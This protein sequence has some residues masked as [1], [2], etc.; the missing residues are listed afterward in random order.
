MFYNGILL[1]NQAWSSG[2][3]QFDG[4]YSAYPLRFDGKVRNKTLINELGELPQFSQLPDS[5]SSIS[6]FDYARGDYG[7][8]ILDL[9]V[10]YSA[11]NNFLKLS[12][13]KRSTMG[14]SAHYI[15]PLIQNNPIHQSYRIDYSN[16]N[17][18]E[19][20]ELSVGRYITKS[21]IPDLLQNGYENDNIF[22]SALRY[23]KK[24]NN[25]TINS[26]ASQFSQNRIL[27]HSAYSDSSSQFINSTVF[28]LQIENKKGYHFGIN[29]KFHQLNK[30]SNFRP[31]KRS[32]VYIKKDFD[33]LFL[34][35]GTQISDKELYQP[36][37]FSFV[38]K[39]SFNLGRI[40]FESFGQSRPTH[41]QKA[42]ENEFESRLR[43][44]L[45]HDLKFNNLFIQSY[46]TNLALSADSLYSNTFS[47]AGINTSYAF[48][49]EWRVYSNI[50]SLVNSSIE[51]Q[52]GMKIES[53][54]MGALKIF[55]GNM[56][57]NF[58]VWSDYYQN[59]NSDFS[60]DPYMQ[61]QHEN[62]TE[63]YEIINRSVT[64]IELEANV[65]GVLLNLKIFN[66]LNFID[67]SKSTF[68]PNAAYP[69]IGRMVQ[70][71][72][73]WYFEN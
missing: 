40:K 31:L 53:G 41:P 1:S 69:E 22:N 6:Y 19:R 30:A 48:S 70:F 14:N 50:F 4:S 16:Y 7:L 2:I 66:L 36:F 56:I 73:R 37:I 68:K 15:H 13:F 25:W 57:I 28:D 55:S 52:F 59:N 3:L 20:I 26:Y 18:D 33:N 32:S 61:Y 63:N 11:K 58:H 27:I 71:G 38:Y 39:N 67:S 35:G 49:D 54:L 51:N 34:M 21:G 46:V 29:Q 12:A 9:G 60:F 43:S 42:Y 47:Y 24:Y 5:S 72:V 23:Q 10:D 65:S 8:D 62:Y 64:N 17:A 45:F 44:S